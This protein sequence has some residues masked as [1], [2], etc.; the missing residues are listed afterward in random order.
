MQEELVYVGDAAI[1][2]PGGPTQRLGLDLSGHYQLGKWLIA[3][4]SLTITRAR[5]VG[6][7]SS[8]SF[9][10]LAP[11]FTQQAGLKAQ[12][13]KGFEGSI[14][15]RHLADRPANETYSLSADGY[16][17]LDVSMAYQRGRYRLGLTIENLANVEWAEAQFETESRLP[18]E[19]EPVTEI[20]F[21]PGSPF[22][23]RLALTV[24]M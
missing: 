24:T 21:T 11:S 3:D 15:Y 2:E 22:F 19:V 8:A 13:T 12:I 20:H 18:N 17:L 5:L 16:H 4:A 1:V 9:I 6:V 7:E 14:R 23:A 10:P